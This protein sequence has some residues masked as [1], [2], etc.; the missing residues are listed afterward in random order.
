MNP[1][2][3]NAAIFPVL[4]TLF[5]P[6]ALRDRETGEF[7]GFLQWRLLALLLLVVA[8]EIYR[9]FFLE[10][11][12]VNLHAIGIIIFDVVLV[13]SAGIIFTKISHKE[14]YGGEI[15]FTRWW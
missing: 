6:L 12:V 14:L 5:I 13:F 3:L 2:F 7:R 11:R 15:K 8:L 10:A 1:I 4:A 9:L